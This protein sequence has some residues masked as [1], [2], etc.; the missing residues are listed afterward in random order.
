MLVGALAE[1]PKKVNKWLSLGPDPGKP[2]EAFM[3]GSVVGMISLA[4]LA[5][6]SGAFLSIPFSHD[7]SA[8][9]RE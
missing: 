7:P 9:P 3:T 8:W 4:V 1:R 6:I 5:L 2:G